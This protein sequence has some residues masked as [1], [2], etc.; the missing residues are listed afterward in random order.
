MTYFTVIGSHNWQKHLETGDHKISKWHQRQIKI[1]ANFCSSSSSQI[2]GTSAF[3]FTSALC[4]LYAVYSLSS[5][6]IKNTPHV[7]VYLCSYS[8]F[9]LSFVL[10]YFLFSSFWLLQ[11]MFPGFLSENLQQW[12]QYR[13]TKSNPSMVIP[14]DVSV[15]LLHTLIILSHVHVKSHPLFLKL[16]MFIYSFLISSNLTLWFLHVVC[17]MLYAD[18]YG[19]PKTACMQTLNYFYIFYRSSR[20]FHFQKIPD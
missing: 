1:N 16:E 20:K 3:V 7:A 18:V 17:C 15:H 12:V 9:H 2:H 6:C 5:S 10:N 13:N 11:L 8:S 4:V 19:S 14:F